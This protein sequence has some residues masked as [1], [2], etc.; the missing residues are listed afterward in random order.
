MFRPISFS[1][2]CEL[3]FLR[4]DQLFKLVILVLK[5]YIDLYFSTNA[6]SITCLVKDRAEGF[7]VN[8]VLVVA[9][10]LVQQIL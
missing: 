1:S 6:S 5:Y 7:C 2:R 8:T 4:P 3:L 9:F 10:R